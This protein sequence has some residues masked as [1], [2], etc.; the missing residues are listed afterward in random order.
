MA[1]RKPFVAKM[2][3]DE[4]MLSRR[5]FSQE[6]LQ[7]AFDPERSYLFDSGEHFLVD[8]IKR[9][10]LTD[11]QWAKICAQRESIENMLNGRISGD[12]R[13]VQ[14][15]YAEWNKKIGAEVFGD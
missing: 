12:S 10:L 15:I 4:I 6:K 13:W 11:E 1:K 14:E 2:G 7:E 9:H 8:A 3:I 5:P